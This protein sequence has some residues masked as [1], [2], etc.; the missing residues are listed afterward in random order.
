METRRKK[1]F[2]RRPDA[3]PAC[4]NRFRLSL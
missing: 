4:R 3:Y 1:L 2:Y